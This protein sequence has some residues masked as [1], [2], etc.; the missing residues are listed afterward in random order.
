MLSLDTEDRIVTTTTCIS[1]AFLVTLPQPTGGGCQGKEDRV[2]DATS[3]LRQDSQD[4]SHHTPG[5]D[6]ILPG[7]KPGSEFLKEDPFLCDGLLIIEASRIKNLTHF[8]A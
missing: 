7:L 5:L 6:L 1:I 3:F 2:S 8:S 4:G